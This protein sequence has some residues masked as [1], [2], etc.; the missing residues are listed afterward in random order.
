MTSVDVITI[1]WIW[2]YCLSIIHIRSVICFRW[3]QVVVELAY[4]NMEICVLLVNFGEWFE[5][6]QRGPVYNEVSF[7]TISDYTYLSK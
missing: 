4:D 1:S 2:Q 5:K 6:L 3:V 7:I